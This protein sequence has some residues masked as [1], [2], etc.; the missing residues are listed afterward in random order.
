MAVTNKPGGR[1]CGQILAPLPPVTDGRRV[2]QSRRHSYACRPVG[3]ER[4]RPQERQGRCP[5]GRRPGESVTRDA[6]A[7]LRGH[8]AAERVPGR[9][10]DAVEVGDHDA[11]RRQQ[12]VLGVVDLVPAAVLQHHP[13]GD[14]QVRPGHAREQVVLDLVVEAT[15][16]RGGPPAAGDV[17]RGAGPAC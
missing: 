4:R 15:H 13:T 3:L 1:Y 11:P 16:Q 12:V 14:G 9:Q 8:R 7:K 6:S 10:T 2:E 5:D 17:A